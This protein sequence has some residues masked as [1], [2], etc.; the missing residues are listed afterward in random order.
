M[1]GG[2]L[3]CSNPQLYKD[4]ILNSPDLT[5][6]LRFVDEK[7]KPKYH[8]VQPPKTLLHTIFKNVVSFILPEASFIYNHVSLLYAEMLC[9]RLP[10]ESYITDF[11]KDFSYLRYYVPR[12]KGQKRIESIYAFLGLLDNEEILEK[13]DELV[14]LVSDYLP[15]FEDFRVCIESYTNYLN[16]YCPPPDISSNQ[17]KLN[18]Y[19]NNVQ[20]IKKHEFEFRGT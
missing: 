16:R 12:D 10:H 1:R 19:Y 5:I 13:L 9:R 8:R 7:G 18:N 2:A 3:G 14:T 20:Y 6:M 17:L 15:P 11:F 4:E